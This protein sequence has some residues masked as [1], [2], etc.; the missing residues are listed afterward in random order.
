MS[1][2]TILAT[3]LHDIADAIRSSNGLFPGPRQYSIEKAIYADIRW[4]PTLAKKCRHETIAIE[5]SNTLRPPILDTAALDLLRSDYGYTCRVYIATS[6]TAY[7]SPT[8]RTH[9]TWAT[10]QGF[11]IITVDEKQATVEKD[12]IALGQLI[13]RSTIRALERPL[14]RGAKTLVQDAY[15]TY[16]TDP[17]QGLQ[18]ISQDIESLVRQ[19]AE[20]AHRK[21]VIPNKL[22]K[23]TPLAD[24]IDALYS[25]GYFQNHRAAL[26][27]TRAFFKD[28]R[29]TTSHPATTKAKIAQAS[30][31]KQGFQDACEILNS[32]IDAAKQLKIKLKYE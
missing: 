14:P 18:K 2:Y 1:D 30:R 27:K 32:I 26:G 19:F 4:A 5:V 15:R 25:T 20:H 21:N 24:V 11:G 8:E 10:A 3:E 22:T 12:T 13:P 16:C 31:I 9:I 6:L 17:R 7:H 23:K 28:S 29:N